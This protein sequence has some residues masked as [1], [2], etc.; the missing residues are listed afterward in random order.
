VGIQLHRVPTDW[1]YVQHVSWYTPTETIWTLALLVIIYL[2]KSVGLVLKI[3]VKILAI[4]RDV[5]FSTI[6]KLELLIAPL[7]QARAVAIP[8]ENPP[9]R[10]PRQHIVFEDFAVQ[11]DMGMENQVDEEDWL[12]EQEPLPE[13]EVLI[14]DQRGQFV[15]P[16]LLIMIFVMII[17]ALGEAP[18]NDRG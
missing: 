14:P 4:L 5:L 3:F 2:C 15:R 16:H 12:I 8:V 17:G 1:V 11:V 7:V 18:P 9:E 10:Q 13:Q 6:N